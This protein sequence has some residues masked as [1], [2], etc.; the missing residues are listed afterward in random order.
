MGAGVGGS[1][2]VRPR[3]SSEYRGRA[4]PLEHGINLLCCHKL[5]AHLGSW[6]SLMIYGKLCKSHPLST[7]L[8]IYLHLSITF[9]SDKSI[10]TDANIFSIF[11]LFYSA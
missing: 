4:P 2:S 11:L 9:S 8:S 7:C 10:Y 1:V 6:Y 5:L 3:E